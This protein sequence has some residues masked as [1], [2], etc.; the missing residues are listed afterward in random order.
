MTARAAIRGPLRAAAGAAALALFVTAPASAQEGEHPGRPVYEQWCAGC[1]GTEGAGDGPAADWMLPRPRDFTKALYQIRTTPSGQ[2]PTDED[3]LRVIDR[4]MPGTT[5][6]GWEGILSQEERRNLVEYLKTFSPFFANSPA[7]EP[8]EFSD[9]PS[10]SEER[11]AEGREVYERVECY[12]CHGDAGRGEGTS[13]P[14]LEDDEDRLIRAA[15]LTENWLFNG[16]G[17]VEEIFRRMR[18]GLDGTPMPSQSDLIDA[19][20]I[21]EEE[22]WSLA[23]YVRSLSPQRTPPRVREV[24]EAGLVPEG[25]L[26]SEVDAEAWQGADRFYIPLVAQIIVEQRWFHPRVD[27]IWVQALHDGSEMALRLSWSDPSE[28]PDSAWADWRTRTLG[29]LQPTADQGIEP[30]PV[31]DRISVQF[32][33]EVPEGTERPYFLMGDGANP[34]YLWTWESTGSGAVEEEARGM[35]NISA[36]ADAT[37]NLASDAVWEDGQWRVLLRRPLDAAEDASEIGFTVGEMV[38]VAFFAWDGDNG[39]DG[40]RSAVSSW[41][42]LHLGEETPA[43]VYVAPVAAMAIT[44]LLGVGVV[45]RAQKRER[46]SRSGSEGEG[47]GEG[48]ARRTGVREEEE[49][50]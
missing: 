15:D 29:L 45:A 44:A 17:T 31:P 18:T 4:G 27:G 13:A 46:E 24:V 28:S 41:Y 26:P 11:I 47:R 5:M 37:Q 22:L 8:M 35:T 50:V 21:T 7:P 40:T 9:A 10:S 20:V 25:S 43:T 33:P 23:H 2:L 1:H 12:R 34:V 14:T 6:P 42:F 19:G 38:P 48:P 3:I 30:A 39:E 16:G 36:H 49:D 32:P